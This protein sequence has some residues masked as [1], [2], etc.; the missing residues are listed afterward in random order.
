MLNKFIPQSCPYCHGTQYKRNG[1]TT[2]GL[3]KYKCSD[4][5]KNFTITTGTIFQDHKLSISEWI[6]YLLNLFGYSSINLNSKM[7]K[8]SETTS[9][10]WLAK[11]FMLLSDYQEDIILNDCVMIDE[12]YYS[13]IKS[14]II[15]KD[16]KKLR[17]LSKN[18]YCIGIGCDEQYLYCKLEGKAK[19]SDTKTL[20]IFEEHIRPHSY[21]IHDN[22]KSHHA[23]VQELQLKS[24]SYK[25]TYLS[26]LSDKENPLDKI[27]HYCYLFKK[28]LNAH[29]G[30]NRE[31]LQGYL[32][33]FS[34]M[35]NPPHYKL[36]KFSIL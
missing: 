12:T 27:N 34:F 16:K 22:E 28:F 6:E 36:E 26:E 4:C 17:G 29:S 18:K 24:E 2:Y 3:Q 15:T 21:L 14:D 19:T 31:E 35:M 32:N 1:H 20:Q 8:N 23:L 10:Y 7:N 13:V 5:K 30:F 33:L 25:L 11:I 9:K